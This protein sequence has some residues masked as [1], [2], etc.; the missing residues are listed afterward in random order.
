MSF[1]LWSELFYI[2]IT[3][4][5]LNQIKMNGISNASVKVG[6]LF[7][8]K[9]FFTTYIFYLQ[10]ILIGTNSHTSGLEEKV[11]RLFKRRMIEKVEMEFHLSHGCPRSIW[12]WETHSI[13]QRR[14]T[15]WGFLGPLWSK[16]EEEKENLL[17]RCWYMLLPRKVFHEHLSPEEQCSLEDSVLSRKSVWSCVV[18]WNRSWLDKSK[19]I[20]DIKL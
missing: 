18:N 9:S 16:I 13:W 19:R 4:L 15:L 1:T 3:F 5:D 2:N 6:Q 10:C 20:S 12:R 8:K 11:R 7:L 14:N 17:Y